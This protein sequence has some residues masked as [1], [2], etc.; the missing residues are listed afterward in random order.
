MG[1]V[2]R[3]KLL[4]DISCRLGF[5][6]NFPLAGNF[7]YLDKKKREYAFFFSPFLSFLL[8]LN[9]ELVGYP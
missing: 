8:T 5:F 9:F 7:S 4:L 6:F 1:C 2:E 3:G